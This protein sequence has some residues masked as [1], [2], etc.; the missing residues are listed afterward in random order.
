MVA[1]PR[2]FIL[3]LLVAALAL[4]F[5]PGTGIFEPSAAHAQTN[6]QKP[7]R[8]S[9]LDLLFGGALRKNRDTPKVA[10]QPKAKRVK[11]GGTA[12]GG[13]QTGSAAGRAVDKNEDAARVLVIGDFM[14]GGLADGLQEIFAENPAIAVVDGSNGLSGLVRDDVVN[15]PVR[16][17]ELIEQS[18]PVVVV[19][20]VGMNDRQQMRTA[21]GRFEK[22]TEEWNREYER[23]ADALARTV[24]EKRLPMIWVGLPPVSKTNMNSDYLEFNSLYKRTVENYGGLFVD[25]WDGFVDENGRYARSGPDIN[26]QIVSL[27]GS[28]GINMTKAGKNKLGF[29]AE[30]AVKR[31]TGFGK[32][33]QMSGIGLLG[34]NSLASEPQYDP[35][36]SGKTVVIALGVPAADGGSELEGAE[37]FLT[38]SD[39]SQSNSYSLVT[40][41][42]FSQPQNGRIDAGWGESATDIGRSET[43]E[44]VL[45]NIRGMNLRSFLDEPA[46]VVTPAGGDGAG[47]G[48]ASIKVT[49]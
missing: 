14:A 41:G 6:A 28:D 2:N 12:A 9:L 10:S 13:T 48:P 45:A 32:E 33:F 24:R 49:N 17:A 37:G 20:L 25:V 40:R 7:Q 30:K 35:A 4:Q 39:A 36:S 26:G 18:R 5:L 43:P 22:S 38:A 23:R 1:M 21:Q 47:K 15:W 34:D 31:M 29:Y 44:P 8:K 3:F 46:V 16:A 19:A 42:V 11:V 27:R